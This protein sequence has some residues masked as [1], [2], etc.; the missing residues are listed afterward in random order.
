VTKKFDECTSCH[1]CNS[2][3]NENRSE[4]GCKEQ[5]ESREERVDDRDSDIEDEGPGTSKECENVRDLWGD[6]VEDSEEG[7]EDYRPSKIVE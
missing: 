4:V 2:I 6:G 1:P 3:G 5:I 7:G